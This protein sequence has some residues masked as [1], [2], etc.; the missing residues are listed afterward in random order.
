MSILQGIKGWFSSFR[1]F[2]EARRNSNR[3]SIRDM[4]S[5]SNEELG[6]EFRKH[7]EWKTSEKRREELFW[8]FLFC[9]VFPVLVE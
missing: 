9:L 7:G 2:R 3:L 8:Q 6:R 4:M 1:K 5:M